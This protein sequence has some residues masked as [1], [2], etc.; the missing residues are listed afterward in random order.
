MDGGR[1]NIPVSHDT[2]YEQHTCRDRSH[3]WSQDASVANFQPKVK[4]RLNIHS[5]ALTSPCAT[6]GPTIESSEP[7]S[8]QIDAAQQFSLVASREYLLIVRGAFIVSTKPWTMLSACTCWQ[9]GS[10]ALSCGR[11]MHEDSPAS[12]ENVAGGIYTPFA[13]RPNLD[14]ERQM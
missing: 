8:V 12:H 4:K 9:C 11:D 10:T 7:S 6:F 2:T 5:F 3:P 1:Q 14:A 13:L